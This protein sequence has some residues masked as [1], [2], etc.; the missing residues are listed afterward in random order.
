MGTTPSDKRCFPAL[1]KRLAFIPW[2]HVLPVVTA[3]VM[4]Q[5]DFGSR[6]ER[7]QARLKY[8]IHRMGLEK[9]KETVEEYLTAAEEICGVPVGTVP[10]PLKPPHAA[11]VV[12]HEDHLGWHDQGD[13]RCF[14]GLPVENGRVKDE[15][16]MRLKSA[17]R[18]VLRKYDPPGRL[19]AH[20]NIL[21][22]DLDPNWR[23]DIEQ[24][25]AAHGVA[26][27]DE[28]S[29]VRRLTFAC[30]ALPTCGLAI[31]ESERVAP[32]LV[33]ELETE[34]ARLGLEGEE[35]GLHMTGCPNG[36]ARPYNTD[37]GIVG[38]SVDGKSGEG[39]YTIFLGGNLIGT[40]M[41]NIYKDLVPL[42]QIVTTL[43]P[44]FQYFK[45][46][47]EPG[48]TLGDFCDRIGIEGL[49]QLDQ[50]EQLA[51]QPPVG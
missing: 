12:Q 29:N 45:Q 30:P 28:I 6:S 17:L 22:C 1:G 19:T 10:R 14:L 13:G 21:L 20:Q 25:L 5:R 4:V 8:T 34:M 32:T 44:V 37:I 26:T 11:D 38:R 46:A 18:E 40:R 39:K 23:D 35:F 51:A 47:R 3:I 16:E 48:E 24:I 41:G 42:S 43:R 9:F 49:L 27:A 2:E 31:T 50:Q 33:A 7:K 36:C 15:G